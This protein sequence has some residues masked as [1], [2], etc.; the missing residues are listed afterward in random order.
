MIYR[1]KD[2]KQ[3]WKIMIIIAG[4]IQSE[5][6]FVFQRVPDSRLFA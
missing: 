2:Q 4:I 6:W 3:I 5:A 1:Q